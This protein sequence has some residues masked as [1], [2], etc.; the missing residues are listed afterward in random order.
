MLN[1]LKDIFKK[2][3][4][5]T[6][7]QN[8][9]IEENE[10]K[11]TDPVILFKL[12]EEQKIKRDFQKAIY[13]LEL[14]SKYDPDN[15]QYKLILST[16]YLHEEDFKKGWELYELR[17]DFLPDVYIKQP[18][19]KW[20]GEDRKNQKIIVFLEQGFGDCLMFARF[21]PLLKGTFSWVALCTTEPL[22]PLFTK[23]NLGV[24]EII[25][26]GKGNIFDYDCYCQLLS[27]PFLVN[28]D[29][30]ERISRNY[31]YLQE[32]FSPALEN[33][34]KIKVGICFHGRLDSDYEKSRAF[35][36]NLLKDIFNN[37]DYEFHS[38]YQPLIYNDLYNDL[39]SQNKII[40]H[41]EMFN[42]F[43]KTAQFIKSMDFMITTDTAIAHLSGALG[44]DTHLLLP[45]LT[46]WRWQVNSEDSYWYPH[47]IIHRQT[48]D[49]NWDSVAEEII[50]EIR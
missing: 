19:P 18:I 22:S 49:N 44:K 38:F 29:S 47:F 15:L 26:T 1:K 25:Q 7:S 4:K 10:N 33:N 12:F 39:I 50:Q 23:E 41:P 42:D 11:I 31:N 3:K 32:K 20:R 36:L 40:E 35:N 45:R 17:F 9:F 6:D 34:K 27:L 46:D 28:R 37:K 14:A 21:L 5:T 30:K 8:N 13:Y 24:D 16:L 2:N 48:E 43:S